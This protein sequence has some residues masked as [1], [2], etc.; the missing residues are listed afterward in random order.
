MTAVTEMA[1]LAVMVIMMKMVTTFLT[2][3]YY[4]DQQT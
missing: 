2:D 4:R 3:L 1:I